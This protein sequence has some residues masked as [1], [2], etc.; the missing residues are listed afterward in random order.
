MSGPLTVARAK[1]APSSYAYGDTFRVE[2]AG[3]TVTYLHNDQRIY[4]SR[5]ASEGTIHVGC[6]LYASGDTIE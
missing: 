6:A 4:T 1:T 3:G 5:A 2:R